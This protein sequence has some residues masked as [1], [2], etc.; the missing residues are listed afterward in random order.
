MKKVF[1]VFLISVFLSD[2]ISIGYAHPPDENP[3]RTAT[4]KPKPPQEVEDVTATSAPQ[5]SV[6]NNITFISR[7]LVSTFFEPF[8]GKKAL[9]TSLGES[10][11]WI[12]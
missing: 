1:I 10:S 6:L 3:T 9:V 5:S 2:V 8:T 4:V 12:R 11:P 7:R